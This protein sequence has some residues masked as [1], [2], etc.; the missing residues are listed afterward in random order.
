[1]LANF[2]ILPL[3]TLQWRYLLPR[4]QALT[5]SILWGCVTRGIAAMNTLP[6]GGGH[7]VAVGLL[8]RHTGV[9]GSVSLLALEQLCDGFAKLALLLAALPVAPMPASLHQAAWVLSAVMVVSVLILFWLAH[10]EPGAGRAGWRTRW[11][12]HLEV[13][14]RPTIFTAAVGLSL[15]IKVVSLLAVFAVQRSLGVSLPLTSTL[16]ILAAV[17]FATLLSIAPSDLGVYEASAFAAYRLLG[18]PP[19]EA[20]ALGLLQHACFLFPLVGTGY[21]LTGWQALR[22]PASARSDVPE[23]H[24]VKSRAES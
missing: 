24:S 18:V 1:V 9:S 15:L 2:A 21:L 7:A 23:S 14:K 12:H 16:V 13:L 10:H 19:A 6:F 17:T 8:A 11:G 22:K 4:R 20:L 3:L 5:W